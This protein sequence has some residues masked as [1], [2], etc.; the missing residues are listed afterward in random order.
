M[1]IKLNDHSNL[2]ITQG[3]LVMLI[4]EGRKCRSVDVMKE[5]G[6]FLKEKGIFSY[7]IPTDDI[8]MQIETRGNLNSLDMV[9]FAYWLQQKNERRKSVK[10]KSISSKN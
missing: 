10:R 6:Q 5:M 4:H 1:N 7:I 2:K 3:G 8:F 9:K